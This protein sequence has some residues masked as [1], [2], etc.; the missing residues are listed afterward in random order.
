[1]H[2]SLPIP[3][4]DALRHSQQL[5]QLLAGE[6]TAQGGEMAFSRFMELAL[7]APG[8]GYYSAGASKIGAAGDF[9]TAPEMGGLFAATIARAIAPVLAQIGARAQVM[10][11][12]GGTGAFAVEVMRALQ[13]LDALPARYAILEPSADLDRKSVV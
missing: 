7:Y 5:S 8:W 12:G 9:T 2:A 6:I 13:A 10:E 4:D 1:M 3:S 11:L